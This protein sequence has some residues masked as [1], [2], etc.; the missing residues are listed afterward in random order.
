MTLREVTM[1]SIV[2]GV[3]L[4]AGLCCKKGSVLAICLGA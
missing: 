3:A 1:A 2:V 4:K